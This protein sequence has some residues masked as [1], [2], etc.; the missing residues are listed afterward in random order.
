MCYALISYVYFYSYRSFFMPKI[1]DISIN[2]T[3]GRDLYEKNFR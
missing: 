1:M 2:P 3:K